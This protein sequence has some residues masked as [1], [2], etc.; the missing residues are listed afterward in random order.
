M[1]ELISEVFILIAS[2]ALMYIAFNE[3]LVTSQPVLKKYVWGLLFPT[4]L[5]VMIISI[6]AI[7]ITG[8]L[9]H[10][11]TGV[12]FSIFIYNSILFAI[13]L[14]IIKFRQSAVAKSIG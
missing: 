3:S 6:V 1:T 7:F 4:Y 10:I 13:L 2:S 9:T 14:T 11:L 8:P 12:S 5:I